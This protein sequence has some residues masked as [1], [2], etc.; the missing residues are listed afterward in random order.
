MAI[1]I[2]ASAAGELDLAPRETPLRPPP[3]RR[4][5]AS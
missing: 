5:A 2:A 4:L 3:R 1:F